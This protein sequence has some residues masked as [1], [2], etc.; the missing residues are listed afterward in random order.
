MQIFTSSKASPCL[1][2][3]AETSF[4]KKK[5]AEKSIAVQFEKNA[6]FSRSLSITPA[7]AFGPKR[8]FSSKNS[9]ENLGINDAS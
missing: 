2:H 6:G 5:L 1:G 3:L 4:L 9:C 8:V 7:L